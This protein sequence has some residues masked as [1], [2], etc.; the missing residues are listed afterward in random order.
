MPSNVPSIGSSGHLWAR[1]I[2][3]VYLVFAGTILC[4]VGFLV[5][6][7]LDLVRSDYYQQEIQ[8]QSH[9]DRLQRTGN[10]PLDLAW[11]I[12][13]E[14]GQLICHFPID[15][16]EGIISGTIHLYRPANA[17]LDQQIPIALNADGRQTLA[18]DLP[19]GLWKLKIDW[20]VN[21]QEYYSEMPV[22]IRR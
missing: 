21:N 7:R 2:F 4:G 17:T 10:L 20:L 18:T 6:R 16:I 13:Q 14:N 9:I 5:T 11:N 15:R 3:A 1:G 12:L 19:L 8:H 22:V